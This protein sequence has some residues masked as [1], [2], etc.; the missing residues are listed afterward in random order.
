MTAL[1]EWLVGIDIALFRFGN[2]TLANPAGDWFFPFITEIDYFYI[3]YSLALAAL[4]VFGKKRGVVT[5]LLLLLAITLSD[6]ISSSLI[7]PLVGRLRP[8]AVLD[9]VRLLVP[10]GP[11]KSFPSSHAVNNFMAAFLVGHFWPKAR[12]WLFVWATLEAYSRVYVGVHYPSD[13]LAGALLGCGISWGVIAVWT[14]GEK[15]WRKRYPRERR[16]E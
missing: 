13:I 9:H 12:P 3:P 10:C 1:L 8:C 4:M 2:Q 6:Q 16:A 15:T 7:K 14:A 5:V 11:G